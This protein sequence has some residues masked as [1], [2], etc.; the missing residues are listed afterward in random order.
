ML[1]EDILN[2]NSKSDSRKKKS[3]FGCRTGWSMMKFLFSTSYFYYLLWSF[4]KD[5]RRMPNGLMIKIQFLVEISSDCLRWI[6]ANNNKADKQADTSIHTPDGPLRSGSWEL[7][8]GP[9]FTALISHG[10][11]ASPP[12][13]GEVFLYQVHVWDMPSQTWCTQPSGSHVHKFNN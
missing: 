6:K 3:V 5:F 12:L 9:T 2:G 4:C 1:I 13:S 8:K 11:Q 7:I 10:T